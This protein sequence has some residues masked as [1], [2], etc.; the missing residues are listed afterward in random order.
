MRTPLALDIGNVLVRLKLERLV[1]RLVKMK[2]CSLEEG[3]FFQ[4]KIQ[5]MLDIGILTIETAL[6]DTFNIT[7]P[8]I[9]ELLSVWD[10]TIEQVEPINKVLAELHDQHE[11][12]LLSN[13]GFDHAEMIREDFHPAFNECIQHFSCEVGVRKP[14]KLFF[15]SFLNEYPYF[16]RATYLDDLAHNV[17]MAKKCGFIAMQFTIE[18]I[19]D[20][21]KA[22]EYLKNNVEKLVPHI[23][24]L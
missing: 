13:I 22:A 7:M 16:R 2:L 21:N 24:Q 15:S 5:P 10:T 19:T 23:P 20:D 8:Q 9:E 14:A 1:D 4:Q 11:V 6:K 17:H 3:D 18:N 12:A